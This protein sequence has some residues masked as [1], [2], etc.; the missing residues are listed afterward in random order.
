MEEFLLRRGGSWSRYEGSS[1][2]YGGF[3]QPVIARSPSS[4]TYLGQGH[5]LL[6]RDR[7]SCHDVGTEV[8][9]GPSIAIYVMPQ[10]LYPCSVPAAMWPCHLGSVS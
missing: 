8:M 3:A 2:R 10:C 5:C 7:G 1:L 6:C 4:N 9:Q